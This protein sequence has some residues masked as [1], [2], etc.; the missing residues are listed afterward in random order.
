MV[1]VTF[2][3]DGDEA[4]R[5]YRLKMILLILVSAFFLFMGI[6]LLISV[7]QLKDPFTFVISF[8][9]ANLMI[10]ISA[11]LCLGFVIRLKRNIQSSARGITP[12][13]DGQ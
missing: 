13:E 11:A 9:A 6:M 10:L 4:P 1:S 5:M 12:P 7:Y 2:W 3:S 8:F